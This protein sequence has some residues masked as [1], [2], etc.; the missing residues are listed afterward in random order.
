[1]QET[2]SQSEAQKK[3]NILDSIILRKRECNEWRRGHKCGVQNIPNTLEF[4]DY[5]STIERKEE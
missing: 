3:Q 4:L 1:M 2:K 5:L